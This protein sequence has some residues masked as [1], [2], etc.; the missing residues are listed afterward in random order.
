[1][2]NAPYSFL[3]V[4]IALLVALTYPTSLYSDNSQ[5]EECYYVASMRPSISFEDSISRRRDFFFRLYDQHLSEET[6]HMPLLANISLYLG[7]L[8]EATDEWLPELGS[9]FNVDLISEEV[10]DRIFVEAGGELPPGN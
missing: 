6:L 9:D 8:C 5:N 7:G 10:Y 1:M 4:P 3:I 2:P